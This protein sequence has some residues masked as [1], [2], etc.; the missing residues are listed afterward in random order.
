MLMEETCKKATDE[1]QWPVFEVSENDV[2]L[3][4]AHH[5]A[6][7]QVAIHES[8][9]SD[10]MA[11]SDDSKVFGGLH[12]VCNRPIQESYFENSIQPTCSTGDCSE[13][14][15][16]FR[17][18]TGV[19]LI[20]YKILIGLILMCKRTELLFLFRKETPWSVLPRNQNLWE[21]WSFAQFSNINFFNFSTYSSIL[22]QSTHQ[23]TT[24]K[25][26]CSHPLSR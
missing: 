26:D 8:V 7:L 11:A 17:N 1:L 25:L 20:F 12:Q 3:L 5:A 2:K 16:D 4:W 10:D 22:L 15:V 6:S 24:S 9:S 21:V 13:L 14:S 18:C 19:F 23:P